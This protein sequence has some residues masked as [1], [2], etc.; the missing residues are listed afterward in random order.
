MSDLPQSE[1]E[2]ILVEEAKKT[3]AEFKFSTEFVRQ[4]SF[5]NDLVR[6]TIR[7]RNSGEE[8]H[9]YSQF[10]IGA[11]GARSAVLDN[12][13]IAVIGKQLNTAFNVHIKAD[14]SRYLEVRPG[15]LN[16]IFN[17]D[18]P[19]WSAVGNFR[20]VRPWNEFV[21]SMHPA[22]KDGAPF[23]PTEKDIIDRLHQMIG[24]S[25]IPINILSTFRWTINDQ[26]AESYQKGNVICIGDA[27]H[28]HPPINGLGSNTCISDAM[29]I[30]WK[31]AYVLKGIASRTILDS[32]TME[33]K[34][35]GDGIVRRANAGMEVHRELWSAI[36]L[37]A[38]ERHKRTALMAEA[39][40]DG[41]ATR[42]AFHDALEESD[43]ELNALGIQMNQMY[44]H[45]SLTNIEP[46][47]MEGPDLRKIDTVMNLVVSTY[48]G[49]HLPHVWLA[50]DGQSHRISIL[51][52][53]GHGQFS[54]FTGVGGC[55]WKEW[56]RAVELSR[57][58]LTVNVITIGWRQDY[59]DAYG[60]WVKVRGVGEDGAVLVRPDH[61]VA[62]RCTML[63]LEEPNKL[64]SVIDTILPVA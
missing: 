54:L 39:S 3:G 26:V 55:L 2:P 19:Q 17:P 30:S 43:R 4:E 18:A 56:A 14:L 5:G 1:L 21:V 46:D 60:D 45:S 11:D 57:P 47:D 9:I 38:E 36:G 33:R 48:P 10:L 41:A 64:M 51:D 44:T 53:C 6:T 35:V 28:R 20:M 31:L 27:V 50:R 8:E 23:E 59:M 63:P 12:L 58:G 42:K 37:S 40:K 62:W 22:S 32:I 13:G 29:N 7:D 61:F 15:S 34:P 25:T 16:W 49:Y 24:D 52:L